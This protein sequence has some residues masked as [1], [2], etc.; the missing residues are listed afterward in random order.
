MAKASYEFKGFISN[1]VELNIELLPKEF[2][3]GKREWT[4]LT[5]ITDGYTFSVSAGIWNK[6]K[7]DWEQGGQCIDAIQEFAN[8]QN[9][10]VFKANLN[11]LIELWEKYHLNDMQAGSK[12]Q[13]N[14]V[15]LSI[16]KYEYSNACNRLKEVGLYTHKG[17]KYGYAWLYMPIPQVDMDRMISVIEYFIEYS[18]DKG[19]M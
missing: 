5:P 7:T 17:Y 3:S 12:L 4:N 15:D 10:E 19:F 18:Y 9:D 1:R 14:F 11:T 8:K 13:S 2:H 6:Q 16:D